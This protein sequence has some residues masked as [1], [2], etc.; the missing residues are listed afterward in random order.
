MRKKLKTN[1]NHS[2]TTNIHPMRTKLPSILLVLLTVVAVSCGGNTNDTEAK[3]AQLVELKKQVADLNTQ[4]RTLEKEIA[5]ADPSS[6]RGNETLV[7]TMVPGRQ[8]FER[9][10][11][12]RGSVQ[13]RKNVTLSAETMGAIQS[14]PATEG[15]KVNAG[16]LLVALDG[17]ILR[18]SIK[19]VE[20][21]LALAKVV[22]ERQ[23]NLWKQ[24]IGT[25]IQYLEAKSNYESLTQRKQTLLAQLDQTLVVAPFSGTVDAVFVRSGEVVQPGMPLVRLVSKN[26]MYVS[27]DVSEAHLGKFKVGDKVEV[28][29][30][31]TD[32]KCLSTVRSVGSVINQNNRTFQLEVTIPES[33]AGKFRPNQVAVV[34]IADYRAEGAVIVP[35][36]AILS[37]SKNKYVYTAVNSGEGMEA[38]KVVIEPGQTSGGFTEIKS[39]LTGD[40]QV[41]VK[42]HREIAEG[43]ALRISDAD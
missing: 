29:I 41:I 23:E 21:Q 35:S 1:R 31:G 28:N 40:E 24:K 7:A 3:K 33:L 38:R 11:Q 15:K 42:G 18:N 2:Y 27:A 43:S 12:L 37:G 8:N 16:E 30:P 4:I 9:F 17:S 22:Y 34:K 26:D 36:N 25:E 5:E 6:V 13:S 32:V 14:L 20:T 19:E 39:G 10:M